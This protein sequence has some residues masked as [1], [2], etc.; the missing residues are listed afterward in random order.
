MKMNGWIDLF[1]VLA[2]CL[3][4]SWEHLV[5]RSVRI[6]H[7]KFSKSVNFDVR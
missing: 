3:E 2:Q 4:A 1:K 7:F 6:S 5:M